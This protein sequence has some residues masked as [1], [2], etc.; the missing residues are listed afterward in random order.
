MDFCEQ[1]DIVCNG[2]ENFVIPFLVW[3]KV[4]EIGIKEI[5]LFW[6]SVNA[7]EYSVELCECSFV[8]NSMAETGVFA[9]FTR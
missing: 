8:Q 7:C 2:A 5:S 1:C 3:L 6:D 4:E 9:E